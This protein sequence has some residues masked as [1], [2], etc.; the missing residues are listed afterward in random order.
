MEK[1]VYYISE[2]AQK[3]QVE[4]H[5]LRY[6][7]EELELPIPRNEMGHRCYSREM[8]EQLQEIK[9][10]KEQ[11]LQLKAIKAIIERG[12]NPILDKSQKYLVSLSKDI[13]KTVI[14][15]IG[16]Q[17]IRDSQ[18]ILSPAGQAAALQEKVQAIKKQKECEQKEL[19]GQ[20]AE[21]KRKVE[22]EEAEEKKKKAKQEE[23]EEKQKIERGKAEEKK[24][25]DEREEAEE[26]KR[27]IEQEETE[28]KKQEDM[29][30]KLEISAR[31][32]E[33][34]VVDREI[35]ANEKAARLQLLLQHMITDAV[36]TAN[37]ELCTDV[38]DSILKELDYQFRRQE[39]KTEEHWQKEEEHY[40]KIDEMIR[41]RHGIKDKLKKDRKK[42]PIGF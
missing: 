23:A 1:T 20:T 8:I 30:E 25:R 27:R 2:A 13:E 5:V 31:Q 41:E 7:E 3:V 22:Q 32:Q 4:S 26:K 17:E 36:R 24:R 6:W 21:E 42:S 37:R 38:K 39:E 33:M 9:A 11:G 28:E 14:C 19:D 10:L 16:Q 40:R 12:K 35:D 15:P 34:L 29:R 18:A